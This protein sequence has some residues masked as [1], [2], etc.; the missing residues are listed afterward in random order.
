MR[1]LQEQDPPVEIVVVNS[2][3]GD[4]ASVLRH[5]GIDVPV[6]ER[7][8][9]LLA[10]AVR[11]L[12][13]AA[14]R[15]PYIGFLAADCLAAPGWSRHR[16]RM[17]HAGHAAVA[18]AVLPSDRESSIAWASHIA[19]FRRRLPAVEPKLAALYGASYHRSLFDRY[20]LFRADLRVGEDTEFHARLP[21]G[22]KPV[23]CGEVHAIHASPK[24]FSELLRDQYARGSRMADSA[25]A[26]RDLRIPFGPR[27]C[28]SQIRSAIRQSR[29]WVEPADIRHVRRAWLL[30][31]FA[32]GAYAAGGAVAHW[33]RDRTEQRHQPLTHHLFPR[34][35]WLKRLINRR[36]RVVAGF[37]FRYDAHLVPDLIENLRPIVD[38]YVAYDD[39]AATELF[40]DERQRRL[41]IIAEAKRLRARWIIFID[42]DERLEDGVAKQI[43]RLTEVDGRVVWGFRFRELYTPDAYRVDGPWGKKMRYTLFPL[44][45]GQKFNRALLHGPHH[46]LGYERRNSRL[47]VYHLKMIAPERRAGRRDLYKALD[48]DARF[49][50][51][52]YDY[53]ADDSGAVLKRIR[54]GRG[55]SPRHEDN[56]GLWMPAIGDTGGG[57]APK[58]PHH[59]SQASAPKA[60]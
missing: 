16:L 55:Y 37:S 35:R 59:D 17:H 58:V 29:M 2:G 30:L 27:W 21:K 48:P 50:K 31:P 60:S 3:G 24:R 52:G 41:K 6:I 56:G 8:E 53:L 40:S 12:G 57:D 22:D 11:N 1:S 43:R 39:R 46:P 14:T 26:I 9:R 33:K 19:L 36:P 23:W 42:P 18:S 45:D 7:E 51:I 5:A 44:R 25:V 20:G 54:P 32:V 28:Y 10:G 4:M 15:S 34:A 38:G 13:I 47:N 49:Q